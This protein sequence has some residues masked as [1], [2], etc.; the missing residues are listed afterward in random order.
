M[1]EEQLTVLTHC[2]GNPCRS[3]PQSRPDLGYAVARDWCWC[4]DVGADVAIDVFAG[5]A[6]PAYVSD[7]PSDRQMGWETQ[8]DRHANMAW[9]AVQLDPVLRVR[10]SSFLQQKM[11]TYLATFN[12]EILRRGASGWWSSGEMAGVREAVY[13]HCCETPNKFPCSEDTT[14]CILARYGLVELGRSHG[15]ASPS[16]PK[17]SA[18]VG[19]SY[20]SINLQVAGRTHAHPR[21][22][23]VVLQ[24]RNRD[25]SRGAT[26]RRRCAS[27]R[28]WLAAVI[29]LGV[30]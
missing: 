3:G 10:T 5:S 24:S 30:T 18:W 12:G 17:R 16:R 15:A 23:S 25:N 13:R 8:R 6:S 19:Y 11:A 7:S 9:E 22:C 29:Q 1:A 21:M 27:P 28:M 2:A 20:I 4:I 26:A 14:R